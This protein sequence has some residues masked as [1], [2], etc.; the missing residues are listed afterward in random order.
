MI[1]DASTED[2]AT[3]VLEATD[4]AGADAVFE[5]VGTRETS[6]AA[7]ACLGKGGALVYIGYSFDRIEIDPLALVVPEQRILTSVGNRRA[8]LVRAL[9]LGAAGSLRTMITGEWT[10]GTAWPRCAPDSDRA[11]RPRSTGP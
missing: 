7:L 9:E 10:A 5:L 1:V 3:R 11:R 6:T 8:E 4:G 2:V